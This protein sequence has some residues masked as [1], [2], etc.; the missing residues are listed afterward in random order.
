M[1]LIPLSERQK[2]FLGHLSRENSLKAIA[3][4]M[5]TSDKTAQ[6][7]CAQ[8]KKKLGVSLYELIR[9]AARRSLMK[10]LC[11]I[12][13]LFLALNCQGQ[14]RSNLFLSWDYPPQS[15]STSLTFYVFTTPDITAPN[16]T[17][18]AA[19]SCVMG[20]SNY[21]VPITAGVS[22]KW[23]TGGASNLS[24]MSSFPSAV[25]C[26]PLPRSDVLLRVR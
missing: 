12:P 4:K 15:L 8:L 16:W 21:T 20:V 1:S 24:G 2:D 6:Y 10:R 14:L 5:G 7:H 18:Y 26:P 17:F 19:T 13:F 23:F 9:I 22:S 25:E 3:S 11:L